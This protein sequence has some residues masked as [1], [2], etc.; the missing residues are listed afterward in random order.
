MIKK[1]S[2]N[3]WQF[4]LKK[5]GSC[6]YFINEDK[7]ILIDTGS[8][9]NREELTKDFEKLKTKFSDVKSVLLTHM[10]SDHIGNLLLFENATVYASEQEIKDFNYGPS[11]T[12]LTYLPV[13]VIEKI[14]EK[15][16]SINE[17]KSKSIEVLETPGHTRGSLC[18]YMPRE[19]ILFSGDT[20]FEQG[21]GRTDLPTSSDE[22]EISLKKLKK[23]KYKILCPGH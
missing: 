21:V 2:E 19:K 20:L 15:I 5:F 4:A 1:I 9:E 16:K 13:S 18:F 7:K 11:S 22:L 3:V 12:T 10:H 17:F 14:K 6:C 23:I 8:S